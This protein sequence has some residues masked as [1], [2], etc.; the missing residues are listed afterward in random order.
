MAQQ[1]DKEIEDPP[2]MYEFKHT[3]AQEAE[4]DDEALLNGTDPRIKMIKR[5]TDL[6]ICG[7]LG[8]LY[9]MA[10]IDRVNLGVS[11]HHRVHVY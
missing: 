11:G 1:D 5:K 8:L 4:V 10:A 2:H 3:G 9:T 6:R 7:L